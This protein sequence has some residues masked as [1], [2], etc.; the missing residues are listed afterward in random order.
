VKALFVVGLVAVGCG[1]TT[2]SGLVQFS[3]AA[4][5]P[6][7]TTSSALT[8]TNAVGA[9][10]TLTRARLHLG[11]V[12]LNQSN[13][14][15]GAAAEPCISPGVYV[16][17]VFGPLDLDLLSPT[18]QPFPGVGEGTDTRALVAE[19][20]LTG[21]DV[22]AIEDSTVILDAA[23]TALQNG[24]TIPFR[25]A[26]TIGSN[27]KPN[28]TNP[29]L[30]SASPICHQR[31]VSPI[32]VDITPANRGTLELRVDPRPIFNLVDFSQVPQTTDPAGSVIPDTS[33]GPGAA[34][35]RGLRSNSGVYAFIWSSGS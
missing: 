17:E 25:A 33:S 9:Q 15:S 11:A 32:H 31:I 34:L 4:A 16:A 29:A 28:V 20:W 5:G 14:L 13:P 21:G 27:R 22:N 8:F 30:P 19:V 7:D 12:Y 18:L 10:V 2:G 35:F 26:I 3:G 23:G 1:G 24:E 6:N